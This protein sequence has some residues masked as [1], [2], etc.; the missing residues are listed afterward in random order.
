[1]LDVFG[2]PTLLLLALL[3]AVG[4]VLLALILVPSLLLPGARPSA[5]AKAA[6][7]YLLQ[8]GG[9]VLMT[10][11]GLP[12]VYGVLEKFSLGIEN[13]SARMYLA[14]LILFACGGSTFLWHERIAERIDDA[15]K[16][17]PALLFWYTFKLLG[18]VLTLTS[19]LS[20]FL[21][22]LLSRP[23][24]SPTWWTASLVTLL[25]GMLLSWCTRTPAPAPQQFKSAPMHGKGRKK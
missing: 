8:A 4:A 17:I 22:M 13:F 19:G 11:G 18:Y 10:A 1:M 3:P 5:C 20:L 21:T 24:L 12:A 15:S 7:C 9:I 16:K 25:Y 2:V 6:Y 14:L 23:P